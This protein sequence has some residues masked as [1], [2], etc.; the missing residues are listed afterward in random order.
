M[1]ATDSRIRLVRLD[2]QGQA[3]ASEVFIDPLAATDPFLG[4]LFQIPYSQAMVPRNTRDAARL[5]TAGKDAV[6][7]LRSGRNAVLTY[8]VPMP[9]PRCCLPMAIFVPSTYRRT[10]LT[11]RSCRSPLP[12]R[13]HQF[14]QVT[15]LI[16][17]RRY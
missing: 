4:D 3:L 2:A 16:A 13:Q 14:R 7:V 1:L 10:E 17:S 11:R 12:A 8:P 9:I 6:L 15:F 5:G